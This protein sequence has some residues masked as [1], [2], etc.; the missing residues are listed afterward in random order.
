MT[1]VML[2]LASLIVAG[3]ARRSMSIALDALNAREELARRWAT[4]S[5]QRAL[6]PRC[7]Q[8][9]TAMDEKPSG[10]RSAQVEIHRDVRFAF[11]LGDIAIDALVADEEAKLN[12]N[13]LLKLSTAEQTARWMQQSSHGALAVALRPRPLGPNARAPTLRGWSQ[14][15]AFPSENNS[16][17]AV[18]LQNATATSTLWGRGLLNIRRASPETIREACRAA[19]CERSAADLM[20]LRDGEPSATVSVQLKKLALEET[21]QKALEG[22]LTNSSRTSSLWLSVTNEHRVWRHFYVR[23]V[24]ADGA[25]STLTYLW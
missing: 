24:G 7:E 15:F 25:D 21:K 6:L 19:S 1:L 18:S 9:L 8:I 20:K 13:A 4:I 16:D 17:V 22:L 2:V 11:S 3:F 10:K 12:V 14:V 23:Q 5:V